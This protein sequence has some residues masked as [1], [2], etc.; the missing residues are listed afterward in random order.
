M[1]ILESIY[2]NVRA[3][4]VNIP[5]NLPNTVDYIHK[6]MSRVRV[7]PF[8]KDN[9]LYYYLPMQGLVSY[10]TLSVSVMNPHLMV[11]YDYIFFLLSYIQ[12]FFIP[13]VLYY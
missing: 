10:T 12:I 8:T 7:P 2:R 11:R 9:V 4:V 6:S 1:D 3:H 5:A 13:S